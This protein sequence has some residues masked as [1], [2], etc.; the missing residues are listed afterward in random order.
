[1]PW[2]ANYNQWSIQFLCQSPRVVLNAT[3]KYSR[4]DCWGWLYIVLAF[5]VVINLAQ[6]CVTAVLTRSVR[7][8]PALMQHRLGKFHP[9]DPKAGGQLA[10]A[11]LM[12]LPIQ[13][14]LPQCL[15]IF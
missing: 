11:L 8:V 9:P 14:P 10:P 1:M 7:R 12:D 5:N 13:S 2:Q 15:I 3:C 4:L 6:A